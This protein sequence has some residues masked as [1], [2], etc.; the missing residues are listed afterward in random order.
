MKSKKIIFNILIAFLC[1]VFVILTSAFV[2]QIAD[3][4][5]SYP[6]DESSFLYSCREQD[7]VRMVEMMHRNQAADVK[8]NDTLEECYAVAAYYEAATYY[9]AYLKAGDHDLAMKKK[10]IMDEQAALMGDL[11]YVAEDIDKKLELD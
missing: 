4:S 8:S 6:S 11:S 5:G 7:Y 9:K 10:K 3:Y 2:F 1:L